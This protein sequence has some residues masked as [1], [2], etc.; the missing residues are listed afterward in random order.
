VALGLGLLNKISILWLG[1]GLAAGLL[2]TPGR[3]RLL[4]SGPWL[5]AAVAGLLFVPHV[6][7]QAAHG[8]PTL[9]FMRNATQQKMTQG[10]VA[11]FAADQL[12]TMNPA[13][14]IVWIT[15]LVWCLWP[16]RVAAPDPC[17][18]PRLFGIAWLAVFGLLAF[19][20]TTRSSYLAPAYPM[21]FA[22]GG[23]ALERFARRRGA[24]GAARRAAVPAAAALVAFTGAMLL[25]F[26]LPLLPPDTFISYMRAIG[27]TPPAEERHAQADLPQFY[28]DMF[29][30][31][32]MAREVAAAWNALP[33]EDRERGAVFAQN[34]GE[35]GAL[36][37]LGRRLGL[38]PVSSGHN[39]YW[40]W[41][42]T[43]PDPEVILVL[44][45]DEEDNRAF[46]EELT[47][48]GEIACARCMPYERGL[49]I[50]VGRRP[51]I[52]LAEAWP[53][54]KRFI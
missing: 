11:G 17:W 1:F 10:T 8:W 39:S 27:V 25:P 26:A 50:W 34:Y 18:A 54:L 13:T 46:F 30:W 20:G 47:H 4:T 31:D 12:L 43:H 2:L 38:P 36:D 15:G 6:A 41:G 22:G 21:L 29:G 33:P 32:E 35:A 53:R 19:S 42:P 9:E 28:A 40:L 37:V 16:R 7:W 48:V 44:G 45:G 49:D 52:P 23:V 24:A 5:A 3:R 14:A 51:K